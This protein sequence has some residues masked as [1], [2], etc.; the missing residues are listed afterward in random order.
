MHPI[1]LEQCDD[2][3][4]FLSRYS[5]CYFNRKRH[6]N[7][8]SHNFPWQAVLPEKCPW[9]L[10]CNYY[11]GGNWILQHICLLKHSKTALVFFVPVWQ[12][13]KIMSFYVSAFILNPERSRKKKAFLGSFKCAQD[14][15]HVSMTG[16]LFSLFSRTYGNPVFARAYLIIFLLR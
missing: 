8:H 15:W 16:K 12:T 10:K 1:P 7:G 3:Q 9:Q 4:S 6:S 14:I 11:F 2:Q 5:G 13:W